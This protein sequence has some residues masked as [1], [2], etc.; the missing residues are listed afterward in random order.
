MYEKEIFLQYQLAR[1]IKDKG[2]YNVVLFCGE[3]AD[4]VFSWVYHNY[5]IYLYK[6]LRYILGSIK[7]RNFWPELANLKVKGGFLYNFNTYQVLTYVIVKKNG[8]LMNDANIHCVYP[9]LSRNI[10]DIAYCN[11]HEN[12]KFKKSHIKACNKEIDPNILNNINNIGGTTDPIALFKNC[13]Y[14]D[15]IESFVSRSKYNILKIKRDLNSNDYLDYLLKVLY[16]D[17]FEYIFIDN[18]NDINKIKN[19]MLL[20]I[21]DSKYVN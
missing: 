2:Y 7:H 1:T 9:Y 16:L 20:D 15:K 12:I 11:R 3:G 17:I 8:I 6:C 21:L 19:I 13:S 4:E 10:I 18:Y 5:G 14:L